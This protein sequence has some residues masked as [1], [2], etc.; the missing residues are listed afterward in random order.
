MILQVK[1]KLVHPIA[2]IKINIF[3][4]CVLVEIS[5]NMYDSSEN[6]NVELTMTETT[7]YEDST[8]FHQLDE[9][10][11]FGSDIHPIV[12]QVLLAFI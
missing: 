6:G 11:G 8:H 12:F 5:K 9:I 10:V 3:L 7:V 4:F 2:F 1:E